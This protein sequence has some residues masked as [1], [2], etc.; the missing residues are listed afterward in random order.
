MLAREWKSEFIA[1]HETVQTAANELLAAL[2]ETQK[3]KAAEIL[4]GLAAR[5]PGMMHG[6]P[7]DGAPRHAAPQA[8][9]VFWQKVLQN[10][11]VQH[12]LRQQLL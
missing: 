10:C 6:P 1:V 7:S 4:P 8:F 12:R 3:A 11:V 5:R 9:S 2:D